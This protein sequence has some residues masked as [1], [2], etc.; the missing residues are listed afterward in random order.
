MSLP[1][2]PCVKVDA[3]FEY[4]QRSAAVD[5]LGLR[6]E[7][8]VTPSGGGG[9]SKPAPRGIYMRQATESSSPASF[10]VIDLV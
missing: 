6:Y 7:L 10:T 1:L 2:P 4:L 8:A 3:A 5:A 9:G